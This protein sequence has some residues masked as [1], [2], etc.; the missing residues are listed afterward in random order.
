VNEAAETARPLRSALRIHNGIDPTVQVRADRIELFRVLAN[1]LRN[2]AEAGARTVSI[3]AKHA[4]VTL[5]VEIADD[6][7]GLPEPVRAELFHP[8]AGSTRR[9]GT[10]LGLAIARDLMVAHGGSIELIET[11]ASGTTF[12][13]TLRLAETASVAD[14]GQN[15]LRIAPAAADVSDVKA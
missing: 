15:G 5:S 7:P 14:P 11:G 2:A 4:G 13:L 6:G 3:S 9:D 8:F 12:C 10:G 1:L